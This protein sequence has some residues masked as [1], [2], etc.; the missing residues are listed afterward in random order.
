MLDL[1]VM[2]YKSQARIAALMQLLARPTGTPSWLE[3]MLQR[4]RP[5]ICDGRHVLVV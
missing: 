4:N 3:W 5:D 2:R 1:V